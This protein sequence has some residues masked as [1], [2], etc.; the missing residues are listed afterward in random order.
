MLYDPVRVFVF[1]IP[2]LCKLY[3]QFRMRLGNIIQVIGNALSYI[4]GWIG[5]QL[6]QYRQDRCGILFILIQCLPPGQLRP[7]AL[8]GQSADMLIFMFGPGIHLCHHPL[9]MVN[10][11]RPYCKFRGGIGGISLQRSYG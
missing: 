2:V 10:D 5:L 7:A 11:K 1:A 4:R 3:D 8:T 9:L 6:L